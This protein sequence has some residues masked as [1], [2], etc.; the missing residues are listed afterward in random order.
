MVEKES[1]GENPINIEL[2]EQLILPLELE[3][4]ILEMSEGD[5]YYV[6]FTPPLHNRTEID[7]TEYTL[8][9]IELIRVFDCI[10]IYII[11]LFIYWIALTIFNCFPQSGYIYKTYNIYIKHI[12]YIYRDSS[13]LTPLSPNAVQSQKS[14]YLPSF[15]NDLKTPPNAGHNENDENM[16]EK[17]KGEKAQY[18]TKGKSIGLHKKNSLSKSYFQLL[19]IMY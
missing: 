9:Y 19:F 18:K 5:K 17:K 12:I 15:L 14:Y 3:K 6:V 2:D 16:D 11:Y 7:I 1:S 8:Y 13:P 4:I 10:Y